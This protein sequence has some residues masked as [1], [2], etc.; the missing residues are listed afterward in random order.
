MKK[1]IKKIETNFDKYELEW[2]RAVYKFIPPNKWFSLLNKNEW[3]YLSVIWHDNLKDR[4]CKYD[5]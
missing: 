3:V 1:L 2:L 5:F 4:R